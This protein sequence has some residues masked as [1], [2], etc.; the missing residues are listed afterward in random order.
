MVLATR[1]CLVLAALSLLVVSAPALDNGLGKTPP[2]G[3]NTWNHFGCAG[4]VCG[5]L[6]GVALVLSSARR[7]QL[8]QLREDGER[9][10]VCARIAGAEELGVSCSTTPWCDRR[11]LTRFLLRRYSLVALDDCWQAPERD[12]AGQLAADAAAF[13]SGMAAL[14]TYLHERGLLYGI[15]SSA[16]FKTCAGRAASLRHEVQD[17]ALFASWGIDFLKCAAAAS[18]CASCRGSHSTLTQLIIC[19]GTTIASRTAAS[20]RFG[21]R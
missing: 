2:M 14:G 4:C 10:R 19:T 11:R 12:D 17:A 1:A 9:S 8:Q 20:R 15:Y 21:T 18:A 5:S 13:P 16:G 6:A 7:A 3:F